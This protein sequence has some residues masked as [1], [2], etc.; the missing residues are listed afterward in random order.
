LPPSEDDRRIVIGVSG[1]K[2]LHRVRVI[3]KFKQAESR[4]YERV[5]APTRGAQH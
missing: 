2:Q 4:V 3:G 5:R 1:D